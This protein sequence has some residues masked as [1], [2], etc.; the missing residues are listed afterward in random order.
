MTAAALAAIILPLAF[1]ENVP[2][3][4][5]VTV[6]KD[7]PAEIDRDLEA[8]L[9][10]AKEADAARVEVSRRLLQAAEVC[11][12]THSSPPGG[13]KLKAHRLATLA[14][15]LVFLPA[16]AGGL[17]LRLGSPAAASIEEVADRSGGDPDD[18]LVDAMVTQVEGY[19][20]E[21]PND[22]R[23]WEALAPVY[24][25]MG[26]YADAIR[27]WQSAIVNL[28][29]NA[30]R[31]E[32]L[33]ESIVAAAE[34]VVTTEARIAFD[35]A[36]WMDPDNV[37]ARFYAGLAAKQD[38]QRE[39]AA[40]IWRDLIAAS[41]PGAEWVDTIR[42]ALARLDESSAATTSD[43]QSSEDQ[44]VGLIKSMVDSLAEGL[45]ID[46][47][48]LDGWLRLVRSYNVLNDR[49][50][51]NAAVADA[52]N[53]FARDPDK[54]AQL[55]EG[56]KTANRPVE[57]VSRGE[58]KEPVSTSTAREHET[59]TMQAAVDRLAA[60]L[61]S[62]GGDADS[63]LMLVRSYETLGEHDKV[64][65][66]IAQARRALAF[67]RERLSYFDQLLRAAGSPLSDVSKPAVFPRSETQN[68]AIADASSVDP[69]IAM[70]KGMVDL[71][72]ERLSRDGHD[73]DGWAQLM[74]SYVVLGQ[75]D[76]AVAAGQ[77]ARL[78]LNKDADALRRIDD[79]ARELGVKL[80]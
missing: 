8:G 25:R 32:N 7:Q 27:A 67:D 3:G 74:R 10:E 12:I 31:E 13:G 16:L 30:D 45:K 68:P 66:T 34:G 80:P 19:L 64:L 36:R 62:E 46:G 22:G 21:A 38:G 48:D 18:A 65:A 59:T 61:G 50:K 29:D 35:R 28:G 57:T 79:T 20:K 72:A 11:N 73:V 53:A 60:R 14:V 51:A 39:E 56:L 2:G 41:P 17:Y 9:I 76:Q 43:V 33:G 24:M 69:Q 26:R 49:D 37:P 6:Y 23:G 5:D 15:A 4:S 54:L 71:L 44:Q 70:I 58:I 78:A 47:R 77:R 52:R 55:E 42:D 75:Q 40:R 63:W 1:G